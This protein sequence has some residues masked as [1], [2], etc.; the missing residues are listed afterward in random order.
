MQYDIEHEQLGTVLSYAGIALDQPKSPLYD[1][2]RLASLQE[3][4]ERFNLQLYTAGRVTIGN[5]EEE[6]SFMALT[7]AVAAYLEERYQKCVA[8]EGAD[9][10]FAKQ[11]H[12]DAAVVREFFESIEWQG[13]V[14]T[15]EEAVQNGMDDTALM[16]EIIHALART[17][18]AGEN[19][20]IDDRLKEELETTLLKL[21]RE[22][23]DTKADKLCQ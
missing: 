23:L 16:Q 22:R 4:L 3:S 11:L 2:A 10:G 6:A 1:A 5:A 7:D 21:V 8:L 17:S 12:E 9:S 13:N 18:P 20:L 19:A 14:S 15:S